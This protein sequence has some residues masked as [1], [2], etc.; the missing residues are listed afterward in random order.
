MVI[1]ELKH[2][3]HEGNEGGLSDD[4]VGLPSMIARD[5]QKEIATLR[6]SSTFVS[7]VPFVF[8]KNFR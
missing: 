8:K 4:Y 3:G 6:D 5:G 7:F 1:E 2:E